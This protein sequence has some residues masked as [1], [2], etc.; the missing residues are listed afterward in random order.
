MPHVLITGC[1]RGL[2][3]VT[4]ERLLKSGWQVTAL[5]RSAGESLERL[6]QQYPEGLRMFHCDLSAP[7]TLEERFLEEWFPKSAP[8]DGLVNNAAVAYDDIVS[9]LDLPQLMSMLQV[10]VVAAMVLSKA[11]VRRMLLHRNPGSLVH[12]SSIGAHTGYKGLSMYAATKA[13]IEAFSRGVAREWGSR[14]IRSNCVVPGFMETAMA[15]G[16]SQEQR[17]RI[18][19]RTALN[20]ATDPQS[21]AATIEFLLSEVSTSVTGQNFVVD[22]GTI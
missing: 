16:L 3:L 8:I 10:N 15:Q 12:V 6:S 17:D 7:E 20:S 9:N 14:Q 1:S 2:G 21:V 5:Q 13:A 11:A 22:C 18:Y 19:R 4:V